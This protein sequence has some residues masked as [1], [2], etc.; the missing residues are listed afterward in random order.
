MQER[1]RFISVEGID[2]AGKSTHLAWLAQFLIARSI[3]LRQTREPGGTVLGEK[4]RELLLN[5]AMHLETEALLMFAARNEHLQQVILPSLA[6]GEWVLCDRFS[7][8]TYA[9]QCGGRGL[10]IEKFTQL[11]QW[12]QG[13]SEGF[14]EPDLTLIFDVPLDVSQARMANSRVLDRFEREQAQFHANVRA[15]YLARAAQNPQRIKVIDAN[16]SIEAIQQELAQLMT[17]WLS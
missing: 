8:A 1:G 11:E 15:A 10:S 7:D 13:R 17:E 14:I 5:D 16:R 12:V 6:Q 2:G 3:C 4:L 9:Y